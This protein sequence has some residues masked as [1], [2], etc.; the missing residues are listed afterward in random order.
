MREGVND[1]A[2]S[3]FGSRGHR[4]DLQPKKKKLLLAGPPKGNG[5]KKKM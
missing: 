2:K 5:P 3:R 1:Q 4:G